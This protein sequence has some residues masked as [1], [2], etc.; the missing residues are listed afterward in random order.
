V[1]DTVK[2]LTI[3]VRSRYKKLIDYVKY[4]ILIAFSFFG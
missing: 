1:S 4:G 3:R 2:L